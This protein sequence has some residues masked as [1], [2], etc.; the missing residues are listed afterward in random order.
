MLS[1][2]DDGSNRNEG[3]L[4]MEGQVLSEAEMIISLLA[5]SKEWTVENG[6]VVLHNDDER[7]RI[8]SHFQ[9]I[10]EISDRQQQVQEEISKSR[11]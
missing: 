7:A 4:A 9:A 6:K 5:S 8:S 2:F 10:K 3:I 1:S 11:S